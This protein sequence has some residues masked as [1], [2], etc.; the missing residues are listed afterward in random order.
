MV[1]W[2][3]VR[4]GGLA[5][6]LEACLPCPDGSRTLP[7]IACPIPNPDPPDNQCDLSAAAFAS[8]DGGVPLVVELGTGSGGF[9]ALPDGGSVTLAHGAQG[10]THIWTSVRV[11]DNGSDHASVRLVNR[12]KNPDAGFEVP[13]WDTP[14][15]RCVGL[16]PK[17]GSPQ[18]RVGL[19]NFYSAP[20]GSVVLVEL[21]VASPDG[22]VGHDV[23]MVTVR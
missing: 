17:S 14:Y 12:T 20:A 2:R 10:G 19:T 8:H 4:L 15:V 6:V 16:S 23:R 5:L 22:R 1:T 11:V 21:D 13:V 7:G 3:Q 18:E 9:E